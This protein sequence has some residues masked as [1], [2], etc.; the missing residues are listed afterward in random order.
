MTVKHLAL[1]TIIFCPLINGCDTQ[2]ASNTT[3]STVLNTRQDIKGTSVSDDILEVSSCKPAVM[4]LGEKLNIEVLYEL[5]SVD[6]A[7]IWARPFVNGKRLGGYKAHHLIPVDREQ[8]NPGIADCWFAFDRPVEINEV[9]VF[10]Q[11]RETGEIAKEISYKINAKWVGAEP[12]A[13]AH[14]CMSNRKENVG[15]SH[16]CGKL[17]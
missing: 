9:K 16:K 2:K 6:T 17:E 10:M 8:K 1:I 14:K 13:I 12:N 4:A 7:M 3:G 5:K 11:N 15:S